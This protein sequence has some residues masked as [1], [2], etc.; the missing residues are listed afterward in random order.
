[1]PSSDTTASGAPHA[2]SS[3]EALSEIAALI[4]SLQEPEALLETVLTI[5][6]QTLEAERGFVLLESEGGAPFEVRASRNFTASQLDGAKALST[7]AVAGVLRSGEPVLVHVAATD[8][9]YGPTERLCH[10]NV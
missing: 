7:S 1:M 3:L 4:N 2:Q 9:R 5:A 8:G 6:M 10:Q